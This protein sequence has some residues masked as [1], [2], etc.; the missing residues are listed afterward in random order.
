MPSPATALQ[1]VPW[2]DNI[3]ELYRPSGRLPIRKIF[4]FQTS[5]HK[6]GCPQCWMN[7]SYIQESY[8]RLEKCCHFASVMFR[9][10][11]P[12]DYETVWTGDYWSKIADPFKNWRRNRSLQS[13]RFRIQ[14]GGGP[15]S[16]TDGRKDNV[17]EFLCPIL[18]TF[19]SQ[20]SVLKW[21]RCPPDQ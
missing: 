5:S 8:N 15:L 19:S 12:L 18:D 10:P 11:P 7:A 20:A 16:L 14:G 2:P 13:T 9:L 1:C 3:G 6:T 21:D 17:E 4:S